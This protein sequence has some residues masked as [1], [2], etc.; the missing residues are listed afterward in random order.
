MLVKFGMRLKENLCMHAYT[1]IFQK[2]WLI[3][4][5]IFKKVYKS[6]WASV[7]STLCSLKFLFSFLIG[8]KISKKCV[9]VYP[10]LLP[11]PFKKKKNPFRE[12]FCDDITNNRISFL[13]ASVRLQNA[14]PCWRRSLRHVVV[15]SLSSFLYGYHIGYD[16]LC[17]SY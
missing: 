9:F 1:R 13:I 3:M 4:P 6:T 8:V 17:W 7:S 2:M 5:C 11:F 14:K 15:A 10:F 16:M 12:L